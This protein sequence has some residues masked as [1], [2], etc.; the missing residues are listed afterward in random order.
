MVCMKYIFE[1]GEIFLIN[2]ISS[3]EAVSKLLIPFFIRVF[4][5]VSVGLHL[6]AYNT[7]PGK[8]WLN[9]FDANFKL[10]FLKQYTGSIGCKALTN[11][12]T[13]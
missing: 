9:Q 11:S 1:L 4:T 7:S 6:T 2:L 12:L 10:C 5:T 13:H 8:L 3:I